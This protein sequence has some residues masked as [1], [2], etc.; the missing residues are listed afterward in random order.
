MPLNTLAGEA[1]LKLGPLLLETLV[2]H[3]L[4]RVGPSGQTDEKSA[5]VQLRKDELLYDEAFQIVKVCA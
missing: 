5:S 3:Y 2:K 4:E 1:G